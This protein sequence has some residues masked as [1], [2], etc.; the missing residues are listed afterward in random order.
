MR[1]MAAIAIAAPPNAIQ[2]SK[3]QDAYNVVN[4]REF[5][6]KPRKETANLHASH[7]L[8]TKNAQH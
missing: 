5:L 3:F 4:R 7:Y 2:R 8:L 6:G 1:Q